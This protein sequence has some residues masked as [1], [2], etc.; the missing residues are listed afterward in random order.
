M[1]VKHQV[2]LLTSFFNNFAFFFNFLSYEQTHREA[3]VELRHMI[4]I[5]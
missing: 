4:S 2:G 1:L 3:E 5:S